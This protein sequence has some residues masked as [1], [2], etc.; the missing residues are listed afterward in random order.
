MSWLK[1]GLGVALGGIGGGILANNWDKLTGRSDP[2]L[3]FKKA[4]AATASNVG[5]DSNLTKVLG[6]IGS[7][8]STAI[9]G[10]YGRAGTQMTADA[11]PTSMGPGSY[12]ANRLAVGNT[13]SQGNLKS[14]LEGVLGNEG[15]ADW[16]S[17][18]D[19]GQSMQLAQLTGELNK[20]STLEEILGALNGGAGTAGNFYGLYNSMKRPAYSS[21]MSPSASYPTAYDF[22]N[23]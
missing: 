2:S 9:S 6:D 12:A 13:L 3:P 7:G 21:A 19:F 15:Y 14:G 20:P 23:A 18:R 8:Q 16:K 17:N 10:A 5:L 11:R 22:A 4:P 1:T